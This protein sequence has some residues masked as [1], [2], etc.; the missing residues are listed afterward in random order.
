MVHGGH[1]PL[2]RSLDGPDGACRFRR[3]G[4]EEEVARAKRGARPTSVSPFRAVALHTRNGHCYS[5]SLP[6]LL[7]VHGVSWRVVEGSKLQAADPVLQ[8]PSTT[9]TRTRCCSAAARAGSR[10]AWRCRRP[11]LRRSA[12]VCFA[13]GLN[14]LRRTACCISCFLLLRIVAEFRICSV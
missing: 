11:T 6:R 3:G 1:P 13:D 9:T 2:R 14:Q 8:S 12:H 7:N 4:M 10:S 5:L